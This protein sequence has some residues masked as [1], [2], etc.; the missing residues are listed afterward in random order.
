M[1]KTREF[2]D[3][4]NN[5]L[6]DLKA[7]K[8]IESCLEHYPEQA[9]E[10]KPL[11][12]TARL[13]LPAAIIQPR[14]DFRAQARSRFRSL[15]Y[16]ETL[17]KKRPVTWVPR[18]ATTVALVIGL[19]MMGSGTVAAAGYSMPDE[20]LYPLKLTAERIQLQLTTSS[21]DKATL[22]ASLVERRVVEI[23]QMAGEGNTRQIEAT[24]QRMDQSLTALAQLAPQTEMNDIPRVMAPPPAPAAGAA[25]APPEDTKRAESSVA[26]MDEQTTLKMA[27]QYYAASD[28]AGLQT[29]LAEA[30]ESVKPALRHAITV[31]TAGYEKVLAAF[32]K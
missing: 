9:T 2:N 7:G 19:L 32:G 17:P 16:S 31:V 30:P 22:Y 20:P 10:L 27:L 8:S 18:W 26:E 6:E 14:P 12:H 25:A 23:I 3:I 29:A 4:L 11:L 21:A 1:K 13:L 15:L 28:Q 24:T 5:C